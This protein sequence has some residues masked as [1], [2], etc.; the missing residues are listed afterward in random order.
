MKTLTFAVS[1]GGIGKS[2][3]TANVGAALA[4][5]GKKVVLVEGDP[6]RPLQ[7]IL[8]VNLDSKMIG[9]EDVIRKDLPINRAV[10]PTNFS[11]LF[12]LPSGISLESYFAINPILFAKKLMDL[13]SDFMIIDAPFPLGEAA[14]L[15]LGVCQ[16][17][18]VLLTEDE[19]TLCVEAAID[20]LRLG[21]H[22]LKCVPLGFVLNRIKTP[23]RFSK[24]FV[25]DLEDLLEI[26]C[27]AKIEED[28]GVSKSYGGAKEAQAFLAYDK[29]PDSDF[30]KSVD[31]IAA[32]LVE[33]LPKPEKKDAALFL[34]SVIKPIKV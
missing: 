31:Q 27:I 33:E 28:E 11:N 8:D 6:N 25:R 12:L 13:D 10:N 4:N 17:F 22:Y 19:F 14:F 3:L 20:T 1:K 16:Y 18:I 5:K 29:A 34:K 9:L 24:E 15:S 32:L 26:P 21:K 30:R 23:K 7:L 2:L